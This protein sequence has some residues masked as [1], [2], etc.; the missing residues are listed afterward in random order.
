MN[1][2]EPRA[3]LDAYEEVAPLIRQVRFMERYMGEVID[4]DDELRRR[5]PE[6]HVAYMDML[7]E[8]FAPHAVTL[9]LAI[10]ELEDAYPEIEPA[11]T[12]DRVGKQTDG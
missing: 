9:A 5:L 11:G 7:N 4:E 6:L 1:R 3:F 2:T 10:M 8:E 12:T